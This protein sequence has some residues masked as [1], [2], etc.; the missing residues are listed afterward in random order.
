MDA[1]NLLKVDVE[2]CILRG[3]IVAR[4]WD[5][6]F[7][8]WKYLIDGKTLDGY[9]LEVVAKLAHDNTVIITA[10]LL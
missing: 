10:Y 1:D 7:Q 9:A 3:K 2:N 8:E 6:D 4:Q 5:T